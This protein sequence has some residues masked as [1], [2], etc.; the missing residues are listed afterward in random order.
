MLGCRQGMYVQCAPSIAALLQLQCTARA[1][2]I[3]DERLISQ[4]VLRVLI[5]AAPRS[6]LVEPEFVGALAA[7]MN[8]VIPDKG[9]IGWVQIWFHQSF[10]IDFWSFHVMPMLMRPCRYWEMAEHSRCSSGGCA[11]LLNS[12]CPSGR[13][14]DRRSQLSSQG[15]G[16]CPHAC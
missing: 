8:F 1:T 6:E 16:V 9:M 10:M 11:A 13:A 7:A 12:K 4:G 5:G 2:F 14:G 3:F 15:R